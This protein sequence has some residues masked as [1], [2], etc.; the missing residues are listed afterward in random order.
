MPG[1]KQVIFDAYVHHVAG[2][3]VLTPLERVRR[4]VERTVLV[5]R[6]HLH[7]C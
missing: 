5:V 2:L 1:Q 4:L 7:C 3:P 6:R